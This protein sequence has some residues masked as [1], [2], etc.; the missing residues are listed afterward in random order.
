MDS[1]DSCPEYDGWQRLLRTGMMV[2][3]RRICRFESGLPSESDCLFNFCGFIEGPQLRGSDLN[4]TQIYQE[5]ED[6]RWI[7]VKSINLPG[8]TDE[9][10]VM[11]RIED[12]M[13]LRHPCIAGVIGVFLPS[14]LSRL[15]IVRKHLGGLP[16][17]AVVL[18]SPEWWTPTA[19]AKAAV[20]LVLGLRFAHSLGLF[21]GNLTGNNVIFND[22]GVLQITD[23]C[24]TGLGEDGDNEGSKA[25]LGGFSGEKLTPNADVRAFTKILSEI[26]IGGSNQQDDGVSR[27]PLFVS[28]MIERGQSGD[29]KAIGSFSKILK[30]LKQ[31]DFEI[32]EGTDLEDISSFVNWVERSEPLI[33]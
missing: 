9:R 29:L 22:D 23:F 2:D 13:N 14:R 15:Q 20:A 28:E 16:L 27:L 7:V 11:R 24:V 17:S 31:N 6:K 4:S 5:C 33:E 10:D 21:H 3:F 19:K 18:T 1:H 8:C 32:V 30:I 25:D 12:L 26:V